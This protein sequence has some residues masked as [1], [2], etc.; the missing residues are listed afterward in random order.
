MKLKYTTNRLNNTLLYFFLPKN[1]LY[2]GYATEKSAH[3]LF[4]E[5]DQMALLIQQIIERL[6]LKYF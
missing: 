1:Y 6:S 4:F 5:P 2:F 3:F